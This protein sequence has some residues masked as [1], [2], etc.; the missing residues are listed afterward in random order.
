M[1]SAAQSATQSVTHAAAALAGEIERNVAAALAEDIGSGDLTAQLTPADRPARGTVIS[2]EDAILCGIVWF[3]TCL[4]KLDTGARIR[5]HA[6]DGMRV[7]AGQ[8]LCE[9]EADTRALLTAERPA[10]NFLQLL[11]ATA[12]VT[13]K[14]VDAV[15]GTRASIV[16]TRKTLPGL[17]L[18]QKYAV[19]CGG[20]VNHRLGLYDG[21]LIKE[22]HI[23]AAA[24]VDPAL[25]R[26]RALAPAG[27]FI[28]IEVETLTQLEEALAAGA[29]MILLDNMSLAQMREAVALAAGRAALEAS[30]GVDLTKVRAIAET[31]VDRISI[32]SLT[33]DVRAVDLSLRH[34]EE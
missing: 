28:Q 8:T 17:R 22:N 27:V 6:S 24:G 16:D 21:I 30:G 18:A 33:K 12:T 19:R 5:W 26:A 1:K 13:R 15:A 9:I 11:S 23:I 3:E 7:H 4:R 14:Y 25:A 31:G 2:R 32:G 29:Q 34:V 20:G 10:L